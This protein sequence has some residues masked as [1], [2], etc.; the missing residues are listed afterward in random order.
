M[1]CLLTGF[2]LY[3]SLLKWQIW[4]NRL[5]LPVI[6]IGSIASGQMLTQLDA[7]GFR[8]VPRIVIFGLAAIGI[9]YSL[10]P[11]RHPFIPIPK[12]YS[13]Y[14]QSNSV[15]SLTRQENYFSGT[16]KDLNK[17][18]RTICDR[19]QRDNIKVLGLEFD[20]QIPEYLLW[21]SLLNRNYFVRIMHIDVNNRSNVLGQEF[22]DEKLDAIVIFGKDKIEYR[23]LRKLSS[24]S[25]LWF[26]KAGLN[27]FHCC[28]WLYVYA[29]VIKI[30][31]RTAMCR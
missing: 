30:E 25:I 4:G 20:H 13:N 23:R 29:V 16:Y 6:F 3:S 27:L 1:I 5:L 9:F 18:I 17:P 26:I 21:S 8:L 31:N 24:D 10:T 7:K 22:P 2:V 12:R 28:F 11:I 14:S 15:F 19:I